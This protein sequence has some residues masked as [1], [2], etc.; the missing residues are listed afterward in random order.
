MNAPHLPPRPQGFKGSLRQSMSWLHTWVGLLLAIILYF[1]FITGTA[2]YFNTEITRWMQ[3]TSLPEV[4]VDQM[5]SEAAMVA[6]G[7]AH[8][9]QNLPEASYWGM[10]LPHENRAETGLMSVFGTPLDEEAPFYEVL[11]DPRT[12]AVVDP[13]AGARETGGGDALYQMHYALHYMNETAAMYI[14]GVA[15]MFMLVALLTGI[16]VHKKIFKDMFTFRPG[17]GQRS[18]LDGHN[19]ASV[20]SLPFMVMITY[21][22]L[23]LYTYEYM[24]AVV[25]GAY[26]PGEEA[27]HDYQHALNDVR[28]YH[29]TYD[30]DPEGT[31]AGPL[32]DS[33]PLVA[34]AAARWGENQIGWFEI[35]NRHDGA[36]EVSIWK[37][38]MDA[39]GY[40]DILFFDAET[41]VEHV[42]DWQTRTATDVG[43]VLVNFHY[44]M[45]AGPMVRW[46]YFLS[47]LAGAAMIATGTILW[48]A[49][50]R[51]ALRPGTPAHLGLRMVERLN[52][53]VILGLPI[54]VAVYFLANRLIPVDLAGRAAWEMHA[55]FIAWALMLLHALFRPSARVWDEQ[56]TLAAALFTAIPVVNALTSDLHLGVTLPQGDWVLAGFDLTMLGFA[57]VFA[58]ALWLRGRPRQISGKSRL[59]AQMEPAE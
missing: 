9:E 25:A 53:G 48:T 8:L 29:D 41:G 46:L 23:I 55:L 49:K 52:A 11:L 43:E 22:G 19:L 5:P 3:G 38:R 47:G 14:V 13:G 32:T 39:H 34:T 42:T 56:L 17:K 51:Q 31:P 59:S 1:M 21:S 54:G 36:A 30:V 16:V 57:L 2:G 45:F 6:I 50:R 27:L 12:G 10:R 18:W 35:T 37:S 26:G 44:G 20:L 4:P 33:A 58:G 24:P 7:L 28:G 15:T 40:Y